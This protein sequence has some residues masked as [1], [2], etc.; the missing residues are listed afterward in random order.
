[1]KTPI[2]PHLTGLKTEMDPS[3]NN[4][5]KPVLILVHNEPERGSFFRLLRLGLAIS[6]TG[7]KVTMV[8]SSTHQKFRS[9]PLS[10]DRQWLGCD[11]PDNFLLLESPNWTLA[12]D[13]QEGWSVVDLGY[14]FR[15][16]LSRRWE[17][18]IIGS[19][20]PSCLLPGI[21][22]TLLSGR[23][24]YDWVDWW[25][26]QD[27]IFHGLVLR[28]ETFLALPRPIRY[29]RRLGFFFESWLEWLAPR[30]SEK[31]ILIS[32]ELL[33]HPGGKSLGE[34]NPI[35]P[36]GA[37]LDEI[38]PLD[39]CL[40]RGRFPQLAGTDASSVIIGYMAG[41]HGAQTLLLN[42]LLYCRQQGLSVLLA[43]I[44]APLDHL[45]PEHTKG[46]QGCL[47]HLGRLP[48]RDVPL[49]LGACDLLALPLTT[50]DYDRGRY[51]QKLGD[52]LASGRPTLATS[53]GI[54]AELYRRAELDSLISAPDSTSY[55]ALLA[56]W[57]AQSENWDDAGT[58]CR[59]AAVK[60]WNWEDRVQEY[61]RVLGIDYES[62]SPQP[63]LPEK[64]ES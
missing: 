26:G 6:Q 45:S 7:R 63:S 51:P 17:W 47:V 30:I 34:K 4:D 32:R 10:W 18:I 62:F 48:Y 49:F 19:H 38:T 27:G 15:L 58:V 23:L 56:T 28:S 22:G 36:S 61:L 24:A 9:K 1:M 53:V 43:V 55:G 35:I 54:T 3:G 60:H 11:R 52:Y 2:G 31:T 14:R 37:P 29:W 64:P 59:R 25:S 5:S 16:A 13:R 21:A 39:K 41:F 44:G 57:S 20:K 46:L 33:H 50:A 40:C 42:A 12:H 8:V